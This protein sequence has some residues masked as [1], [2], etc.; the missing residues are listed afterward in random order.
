MAQKRLRAVSEDER[1]DEKKPPA[2]VTEAADSGDR[3]A[4]LVALRTRIAKA[5]DNPNTS[6]RDLAS[7]SRRLMEIAND[8]AAI[9]AA[10][11]EGGIGDATTTP[12]EGFDATAL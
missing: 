7:N 8:I 11:G 10:A 2:T 4:M 5:L 9:D 12:D 1:S 3:R 6:P